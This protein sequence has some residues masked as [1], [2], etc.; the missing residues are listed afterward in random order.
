MARC[1]SRSNRVSHTK[2]IVGFSPTCDPRPHSGGLQ[3]GASRSSW[4]TTSRVGRA[5]ERCG[6]AGP[7]IHVVGQ[8]P[9][10]PEAMAMV[11]RE[12]PDV[13]LLRSTRPAGRAGHHRRA[14]GQ[15]PV[16]RV[17][18][19]A[20]YPGDELRP[21]LRR[22]RGRRRHRPHRRRLR[23][24]RRPHPQGDDRVGGQ[25]THAPVGGTATATATAARVR[26]G[27]RRS[28]GGSTRS[29]DWWL[30]ATPTT[31]SPSGS[32]WRPTRSRPIGSAPC[33]S[34][35]PATGQRPSPGRTTCTS[36]EL[37]RRVTSSTS[38]GWCG[39]IDVKRSGSILL[40]WSVNR[41]PSDAP[42]RP[43]RRSRPPGTPA[44]RWERRSPA[45]PG[46]AARAARPPPGGRL[47]GLRGCWPR[48]G[49]R[50]ALQVVHHA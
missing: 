5:A 48:S 11:E 25:R 21:R 50:D 40:R 36:S 47:T 20:R 42:L 35:R 1:E 49:R 26:P 17:I 41:P 34:C 4:S 16:T 33:T 24:G 45:A 37:R 19:V 15:H 14:A 3:T 27:C 23:P 2:D 30:S 38:I 31:R 22:A 29:C 8:A 43:E 46:A 28:P 9:P 44:G 6:L 39:V 18:L 32:A 12:R 10:G 7:P 13:V